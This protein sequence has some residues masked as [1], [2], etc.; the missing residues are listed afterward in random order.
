MVL[1]VFDAGWEERG[2]RCSGEDEVQGYY[3]GEWELVEFVAA[4]A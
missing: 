1:F 2:V 4:A 3:Q